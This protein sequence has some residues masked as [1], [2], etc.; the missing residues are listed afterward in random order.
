MAAHGWIS[1]L[2]GLYLLLL[3]AGNLADWHLPVFPLA[4]VA[5]LAIA[6][7]RAWRKMAHRRDLVGKTEYAV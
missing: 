4:A 2:A 5:L 6:T 1:A 3:E 7:A